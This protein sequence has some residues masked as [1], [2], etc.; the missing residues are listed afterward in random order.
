MRTLYRSLRSIFRH[1]SRSLIIIAI[2]GLSL[3]VAVTMLQA[4]LAAGAKSEH[5][6]KEVATLLEIRA[7]GSA[8][9]EAVLPLKEAIVEEVADI[10]NVVRI[11]KYVIDRLVDNGQVPPVSM[12]NGV[13]PGETLR[14]ATL[15]QFVPEIVQG[16]NFAAADSGE[17]VVIVGETYAKNRGVSIGDQV[18]LQ[19]RGAK[20]DRRN[21]ARKAIAPTQMEVIG[22][23]SSGFAF[24]DNQIFLPFETAQKLFQKQAQVTDVFLTADSIENVP[25][26]AEELRRRYGDSIDLLT[27]EDDARA[28][29]ASLRQ[30]QATSRW[31][32][33]LALAAGALLVLFTALLVTRGRTREIGILKAI[34]ASN[35]VVAK[36]FAA[37]IMLLSLL[38]GLFA[39]VIYALTGSVLADVL[40]GA[41]EN[42]S[43]SWQPTEA[44]SGQQVDLGLPP[45]AVLIVL[46]LSIGFGV[47]GSVYPIIRATRMK[48]VDALREQ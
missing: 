22:I 31:A 43:G 46:G 45:T 37:E 38:G 8:G 35:A 36:Q 17:R 20:G 23:F 40:L 47:L 30:I 11:E 32:M 9:I 42:G 39:L 26:V 14:L 7:A 6:K 27:L 18:I 29:D 28:A 25:K 24:G 1:R 44:V 21:F 34:G 2:L 3:S 15:G 13:V 5:L 19:R 4:N 48:P 41:A 33:I 16:R 10:P 12:L